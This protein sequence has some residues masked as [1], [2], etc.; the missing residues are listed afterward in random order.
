MLIFEVMDSYASEDKTS[1]FP[2]SLIHSLYLRG[3]WQVIP[4][5]GKFR[6]SWDLYLLYPRMHSRSSARD[7][8][9]CGD[10][11]FC[12]LR[13]SWS[14]SARSKMLSGVR[15]FVLTLPSSLGWVL[16]FTIGVKREWYHRKIGRACEGGPG[17]RAQYVALWF[18]SCKGKRQ[19]WK[20]NQIHSLGR[21]R[22]M[23]F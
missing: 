13:R 6:L 20:L 22:D 2:W 19:D 18:W 5:P 1:P 3:Q 11:R 12:F 17:R 16:P 4:S 15:G 14:E 7:M 21:H 9:E 23:T 8:V 10:S